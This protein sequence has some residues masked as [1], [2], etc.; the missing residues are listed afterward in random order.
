ME[1]HGGSVEARSGGAGQ[2]SEFVA[3]FPVVP[4]PLGPDQPPVPA[5]DASASDPG[6]ASWPRIDG[7]R[8]MVV[9]DDVPSREWLAALLAGQ[10]ASVT[11]CASVAEARE[12]WRIAIPDIVLA[13]IGMPDED[14]YDLLAGIRARAR[15]AAASRCW[16]SLDTPTP[17]IGRGRSPRGSTTT[18]RNPSSPPP[19]W[20]ASRRGRRAPERAPRGREG[21]SR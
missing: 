13:D 12:A 8:V 1:L 20:R 19:C 2:G 9:E 6:A 17:P 21:L 7:L 15:R 4:I 14:G 10:G 18:W 11:V 3:R 5:V 16:R